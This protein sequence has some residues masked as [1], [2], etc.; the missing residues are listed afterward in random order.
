MSEPTRQQIF[1]LAAQHCDQTLCNR[2][3]AIQGWNFG[4]YGLLAFVRAVREL[5]STPEDA[6]RER[7]DDHIRMERHAQHERG[8]AETGCGSNAA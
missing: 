7:W 5:E 1:H 8:E 2:Q 6:E 4:K 3:R